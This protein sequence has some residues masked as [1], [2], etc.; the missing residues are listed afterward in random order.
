MKLLLCAPLICLGLHASEARADCMVRNV[1]DSSGAT[2]PFLILVPSDQV[3]SFTKKGYLT[4][5]CA[6]TPERIAA[7]RSNV[8]RMAGAGGD[9]AQRRF[10]EIFGERPKKMCAA[11]DR[12]IA[13]QAESQKSAP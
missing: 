8:C 11:A 4:Q 10:E 1:T 5:A 12:V 9:F 13:E 6:L 2:H 3:A 7:A